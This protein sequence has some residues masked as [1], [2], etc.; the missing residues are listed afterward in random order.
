MTRITA[1]AE[2][3]LR[4]VLQMARLIPNVEQ[5]LSIDQA[6]AVAPGQR[7]NGSRS[8]GISDP[9]AAMVRTLAPFAAAERRLFAAMHSITREL[10]RA[11]QIVSD[12]LSGPDPHEHPELRCPGWNT[13]LRARLGGCGKPLEHWTD[14]R[15]VQH[16]RSTLLCVSCRRASERASDEVA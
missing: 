11:E 5:H 4:R 15:G 6:D 7:G 14:A 12:I 16:N 2:T 1:E 3:I 10:D 8:S 13:E 9:T